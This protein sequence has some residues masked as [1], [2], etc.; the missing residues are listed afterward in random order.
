MH[1]ECNLEYL[2]PFVAN[3]LNC[4]QILNSLPCLTISDSKL[5]LKPLKF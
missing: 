3:N 5:R 4:F 2:E 1:F